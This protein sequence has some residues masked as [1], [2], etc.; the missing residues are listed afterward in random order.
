MEMIRSV[1]HG[2]F[3]C[4]LLVGVDRAV[5]VIIVFGPSL[6]VVASVIYYN[7]LVCLNL[8]SSLW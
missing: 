7:Y 2:L 4:A 3:L 5:V 1:N 6:W 8:V